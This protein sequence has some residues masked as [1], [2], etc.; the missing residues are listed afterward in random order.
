[1]KKIIKLLLI[2]MGLIMINPTFTSCKDDEEEE[3][4]NALVGKWK[5]EYNSTDYQIIDFKSDGSF[6]IEHTYS[7]GY[8][9]Y[10][11]DYYSGTYSIEKNLLITY[12]K[13]NTK[14][15]YYLLLDNMLII[16]DEIYY[17]QYN[18]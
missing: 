17:R 11:T 4:M 12:S 16:E 8:I 18:Y 15:V 14:S 7:I 5:L 6:E 9:G 13:S 2:A 10:K 3:L 1:M